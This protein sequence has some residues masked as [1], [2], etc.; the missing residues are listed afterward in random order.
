ML[1]YEDDLRDIPLS[2]EPG[3]IIFLH[4]DLGAGKTTLVRA[5]LRKYGLPESVV[6]R[7]PTY[8]YVQ[9]YI[10]PF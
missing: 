7:S 5:L 6:V 2:I 3:D 4:G 8:T 1:V 10:P 9:E